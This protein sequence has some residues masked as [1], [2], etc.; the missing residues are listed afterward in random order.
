MNRLPL[1]RVVLPAGGWPSILDYLC[2]RFTAVDREAW[3]DRM[4]RG[5]V[6]ADGVAVDRRAPY[7]PGTVVTYQR[8][9]PDE[10]PVPFEETVVYA[11][12]DLV[13]ADKPHFLPVMP[14]GRYVEETLSVR[15]VRRLGN[16][17]LVALHRLDRVTAGLVVF[18][19]RPS[20]RDAYTRLFRDRLIQKTYEAIAPPMEGRAF[21]FLH[22]SRIERGEPF[23]R[24]REC[25][26]VA[27]ARTSIDVIEKG[28][29]FWR[30]R[31]M[32]VTGRKHQLR[33]HMA[34]LGA[35][36]VGDAVY[37]HVRD[38]AGDFSDPLRL[39]ARELRF[40]DPLSGEDRVFLSRRSL[41]L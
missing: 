11:D 18:S 33:V 3:S 4:A 25:D 23:F 22:E 34:A 26:G 7:R 21:P 36:I 31:L 19:A 39:L 37:P 6:Q 17:D 32:P 20:S 35:P 10:A 14:A 8:E 16:P 5:L 24:M 38:E 15:L 41:D 28:E 13:V 12:D 2:E 1:S 30:Y 29:H 9:V 27:N 40:V